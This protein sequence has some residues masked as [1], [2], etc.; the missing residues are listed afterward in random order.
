M[1]VWGKEETKMIVYGHSGETRSDNFLPSATSRAI[2]QFG[3]GGALGQG[4]LGSTSIFTKPSLSQALI[5]FP[6]VMG[7]G[8]GL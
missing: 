2:K 4:A 7:Y 5:T 8:Y 1:E 3:C 6:G